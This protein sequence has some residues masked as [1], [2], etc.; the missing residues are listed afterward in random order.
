VD[1]NILNKMNINKIDVNNIIFKYNLFKYSL[2]YNDYDLDKIKYIEEFINLLYDNKDVN[3]IKYNLDNIL[4][5]TLESL[6]LD[7]KFNILLGGVLD[8][9]RKK[10]IIYYIKKINNLYEIYII[11][12]YE[13]YIFKLNNVNS[14]I[15]YSIFEFNLLTHNEEK[16]EYKRFISMYVYTYN[17]KEKDKRKYTE[18]ESNIIKIIDKYKIYM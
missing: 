14:K 6:I 18:N 1:K 8:K 12:T 13:Y 10:N 7:N 17:S 4:E 11:N 5:K 2:Q 16:D 9:K 15:L 3:Y